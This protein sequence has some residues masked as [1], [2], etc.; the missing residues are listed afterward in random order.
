MEVSAMSIFSNMVFIV[1]QGSQY[2]TFMD[3]TLPQVPYAV[4]VPQR[5]YVPAGP[6]TEFQPRPPIRYIQ[7]HIPGI[8]LTD[9]LNRNLAGVPD[10]EDV[11]VTTTTSVR[12]AIRINV[13][14]SSPF[15]L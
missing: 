15:V 8:F 12:V 3:A 10:T 11:I 1:P 9:A 14:V 13:C 4:P 7:N 2:H 6:I 5:V